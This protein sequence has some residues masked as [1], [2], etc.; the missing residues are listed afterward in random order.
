[1][2]Q[3][4]PGVFRLFSDEPQLCVRFA[5]RGRFILTGEVPQ[6]RDPALRFESRAGNVNVPLAERSTPH[7]AFH[8]LK[9][10]LPRGVLARAQQQGLELEV[11]LQE[12]TL[13]AARVPFAQIFTTDLKQRVRRL[14]D[15]RFELLGATAGQCLITLRV[16]ARRT[17]VEVPGATSA[18]DTATLIAARVPAGYRAEVDGAVISLWKD[19]ELRTIAA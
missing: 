9:R 15:N 18:H 16:D 5:G 7:D 12:T 6:F 3:A 10:R 13:P 2:V 14:D 1:M 19:A 11:S 4:L 8:A 17:L